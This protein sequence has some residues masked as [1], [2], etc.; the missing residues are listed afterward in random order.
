[1]TRSKIDIW[2][3]AG[4][5]QLGTDGMDGIIIEKLAK[6]LDLNKSGFYH[7][8]GT[9]EYYVK[10]LLHYHVKQAKTIA[11]E[12]AK[13]NK[14][15][16][17]LLRLIVKHKGFFLVESQLLVKSRPSHFDENVDEAG[18]IVNEELLPLWRKVRDLPEDHSA[19]M[20]FLNIIRHFYYARMDAENINYGFLHALTVETEDVLDKIMDKHVSA[21]HQ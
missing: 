10:S 13:C 21:P 18:K 9:M 14:I 11:S 6:I 3:K 8:F 1:M 15:D 5:K 2:I 20:G 7:Y 4:Y 19:A 16:P 17:D 12:V